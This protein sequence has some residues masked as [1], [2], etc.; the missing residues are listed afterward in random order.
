MS[1]TANMATTNA[2]YTNTNL[3]IN[4][5][6]LTKHHATNV[7]ASAST[8]TSTTN[9]NNTTNTSIYTRNRPGTTR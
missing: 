6:E 8:S 7:S 3:T 1:A 4:R 2:V 5:L 9:T